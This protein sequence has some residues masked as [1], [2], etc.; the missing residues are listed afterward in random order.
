MQPVPHPDSWFIDWL[1][2]QKLLDPALVRTYQQ[3]RDA[4][5]LQE[6]PPSLGALLERDGLLTP[7]QRRAGELE[8][9]R[10]CAE[11]MAWRSQAL[12]D[13]DRRRPPG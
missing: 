3:K 2:Q 6:D 8:A 9:G 5:A 13:H 7:E 10:R 4:A 12:R 1:G 11:F